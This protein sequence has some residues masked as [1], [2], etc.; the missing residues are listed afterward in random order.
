MR[1]SLSGWGPWSIG[2]AV[3]ASIVA[4]PLFRR[5]PVRGVP[6]GLIAVPVVL[7]IAY[8]GFW[9]GGVG[10]GAGLAFALALPRRRAS[11]AAG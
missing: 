4:F 1:S 2:D 10:V 7:A 8:L 5:L 3:G 11:A 9:F 6:P